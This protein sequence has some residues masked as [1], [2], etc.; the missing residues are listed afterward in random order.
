MARTLTFLSLSGDKRVFHVK[1][2]A[3]FLQNQQTRNY[4]RRTMLC[5]SEGGVSEF[6]QMLRGQLTIQAHLPE[7]SHSKT[8]TN[9]GSVEINP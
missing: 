5:N 8:I 7:N 3:F 2:L 6:P 9:S 1:A 4:T